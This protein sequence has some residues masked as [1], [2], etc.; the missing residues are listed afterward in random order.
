[1]SM[2]LGD[3]LCSGTERVSATAI[4]TS[5]IE[6]LHSKK[7]R[8]LLATHQHDVASSLP[9]NI[10]GEIH[11]RHLRVSLSGDGALVYERKLAPGIG[12]TT[13]GVTVCRAIGLPNDFLE[14]AKAHALRLT[15]AEA[16]YT[17]STKQSNYNPDVYMGVCARCKTKRAVHTHHLEPQHSAHYAIK[18]R[19]F[20][21]DL[22]CSECHEDHHREERMGTAFPIKRVQTTS[23]VRTVT[24]DIA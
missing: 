19:A 24:V 16:E 17:V 2:V 1:M 7:C 22:L 11:V 13:Y 10:L 23:G 14:R 3:E 9:E 21:L 20:N 8:F 6:T 12:E 5:G 18:N 15:G 4:I